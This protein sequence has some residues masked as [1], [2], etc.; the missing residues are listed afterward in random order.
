MSTTPTSLSFAQAATAGSAGAGS[1]A[2]SR[3]AAMTFSTA[4]TGA[5]TAK[6]RTGGAGAA[7]LQDS[8]E[9]KEFKEDA[10]VAA[11][12][13]EAREK[14]F[15]KL[16]KNIESAS[17][18]NSQYS[19]VKPE[20]YN[21]L[22]DRGFIQQAMNTIP[23]RADILNATLVRRSPQK[24][25]E[26]IHYYCYACTLSFPTGESTIYHAT[27]APAKFLI[28]L[29]R[30]PQEKLAKIFRISE[31]TGEQETNYGLCLTKE[32]KIALAHN[33]VDGT[34]LY[35]VDRNSIVPQPLPGRKP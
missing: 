29:S 18:F 16:V 12:P 13:K 31:K 14:E 30:N 22:Y 10:D 9:T 33:H 2:A 6:A 24:E 1:A 23:V 17:N 28:T 27:L 11:Q 35:E 21:K 20:L 4:A 26:N 34:L 3:T 7:A 25:T 8:K 15:L 19:E 5:A 32:N